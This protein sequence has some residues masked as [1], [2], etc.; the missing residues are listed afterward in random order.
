MKKDKIKYIIAG[1]GILMFVLLLILIYAHNLKRKIVFYEDYK[2]VPSQEQSFPSKAEIMID[3]PVI[4]GEIL[5][6]RS[7]HQEIEVYEDGRLIYQHKKDFSDIFGKSAVSQWHFIPLSDNPMGHEISILFYSPYD[8]MGEYQ[9][10]IKYGEFMTLTEYILLESVPAVVI[11]YISLIIGG[12]ILVYFFSGKKLREN[13]HFVHLAFF[14]ILAG[15][16]ALGHSQRMFFT[17]MPLEIERIIYMNCLYLLPSSFLYTVSKYF[18]LS[19]RKY[20]KCLAVIGILNTL[21]VNILQM[22]SIRDMVENIKMAFLMVLLCIV[23]IAWFMIDSIRRKRTVYNCAGFSLFLLAS[24]A[25]ILEMMGYIINNYSYISFYFRMMIV[26][27]VVLAVIHLV[28][29]SVRRKKELESTKENLEKSKINLMAVR[30]KPHL[31]NNTLL[32]IQEL[33]YT[34][35]SEAAKAIE[36]FSKYLRSSYQ[37]IVDREVIPFEEE[38]KYIREYIEVQKVCYR[39]E[40]LYREE[41][42]YRSFEVPPLSLQPF[43]ENAVKHGIRKRVGIGTIV[44]KVYLEKRN[45]F[46]E[47][48]DDGVGFDASKLNRKLRKLEDK[49]ITRLHYL[50]NAKVEIESEIGQGTCVKIMIPNE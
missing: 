32:S 11:S 41:I 30:M 9:N 8:F 39:D 6:I 20:I 14:S 18:D 22:L 7:I 10:L 40:I 3:G 5:A 33:C 46:I 42:S 27:A 44:L 17:L 36:V 47:I 50:N 13:I 45:I 38:L 16:W 31:I 29:A 35:P 19:K 2:F 25:V 26:V 15:L 1:I 34:K 48:Q 23:L 24:L 28:V 12:G 43:V 37:Y 21:V 4:R 49:G